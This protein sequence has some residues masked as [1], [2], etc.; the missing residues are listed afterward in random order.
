MK[1]LLP[2]AAMLCT[3][4]TTLLMLVF[5]LAG[6]PNSTAEQLRNMQLWAGGLCLLSL[7]C[8][9]VGIVLMGRTAPAMRRWSPFYQQ[10]S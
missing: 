5:T 2:I 4:C 8:I 1:N 10:R 7:L 6:M 3:A 9:V